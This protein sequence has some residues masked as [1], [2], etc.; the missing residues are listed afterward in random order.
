MPEPELTPA[1][2]E[3]ELQKVRLAKER[4]KVG[5]IGGCGMMTVGL[6]ALA[7]GIAGLIFIF[8]VVL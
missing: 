2:V 5:I 8:V 1:E 7:L 3:H 6:V 4:A